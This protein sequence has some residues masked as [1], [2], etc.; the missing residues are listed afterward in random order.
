MDFGAGWVQIEISN[1]SLKHI[2]ARVVSEFTTNESL[3][4]SFIMKIS[5]FTDLADFIETNEV[6]PF[7]FEEDQNLGGAPNWVT[8]FEGT[9]HLRGVVDWTKGT[10]KIFAFEKDSSK[11]DKFLRNWDFGITFSTMVDEHNIEIFNG[12]TTYNY[13]GAAA[14]FFDGMIELFDAIRLP[15]NMSEFTIAKES[16]PFDSE[17]LLIFPN[18]RYDTNSQ[19]VG[20]DI[21]ITIQE[22]LA[23]LEDL[24]QIY[25]YIDETA[26]TAP[27][28]LFFRPDD[29]AITTLI[30]DGAYTNCVDSDIGKNVED[31][32]VAKGELIDFDNTNKIWWIRPT[33]DGYV[34]DDNSAM[35]IAS[36]TGVGVAS[37]D[38]ADTNFFNKPQINIESGVTNMRRDEY[39]NAK[40]VWLENFNFSNELGN[41]DFVGFP[42]RYPNATSRKIDYDIK[43]VTTNIWDA[44]NNAAGGNKPD[45]GGFSLCWCT[46]FSSPN[47]WRTDTGT[48]LISSTTISN[49]YLSKARLH[50]NWF[51]TNRYHIR[52]GVYINDSLETLDDDAIEKRV[53]DYPDYK[54]ILSSLPKAIGTLRWE[55]DDPNELLALIEAVETD[56]DSGITTYRSR[57]Y[58]SWLT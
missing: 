31:D 8:I 51:K 58:K 48:G 47:D 18:L 20:A 42:L 49:E 52:T 56:L 26:P 22:M 37:G 3:E 39:K 13:D 44:A 24:F 7:K 32:S 1:N 9:A 50:I 41:S 34:I 14:L 19:A 4:G 57:Q 40:M 55:F 15:E 46:L 21:N 23:M 35:T 43:N 11:L 25:W 38:S 16:L 10:I 12:T 53:R 36:G 33:V 2:I 5:D 6:I 54:A 27:K 17:K 28:I 30:L 29:I 45:T